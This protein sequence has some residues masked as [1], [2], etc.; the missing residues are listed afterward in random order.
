MS[1]PTWYRYY[2]IVFDADSYN[3]AIHGPMRIKNKILKVVKKQQWIIA[4]LE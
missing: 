2:R 4:V 1:Y 3:Y